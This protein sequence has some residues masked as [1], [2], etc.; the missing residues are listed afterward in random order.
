[1]VQAFLKIEIQVEF[2]HQAR[3]VHAMKS[4]AY[5]CSPQPK[6]F[7]NSV[8]HIATTVQSRCLQEPWSRL[9]SNATK[10]LLHSLSYL[11]IRL[12]IAHVLYSFKTEQWTFG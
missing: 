6:R 10:T 12:R 4:R 5:A 7:A 3:V 9:T 8:E 1:M 11:V 2:F